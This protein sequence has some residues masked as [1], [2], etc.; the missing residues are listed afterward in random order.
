MTT[1]VGGGVEICRLHS[2]GPEEGLLSGEG[3]G[4]LRPPVIETK[5][6]SISYRRLTERGHGANAAHNAAAASGVSKNLAMP[7]CVSSG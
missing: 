1:G 5:R 7:W 2:E 4:A 3:F 6:C